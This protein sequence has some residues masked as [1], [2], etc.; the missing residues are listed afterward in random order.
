MKRPDGAPRASAILVLAAIAGVL[1]LVGA[2]LLV[3]PL[4]T[5]AYDGHGLPI[6]T[7]LLASRA[8][9]LDYYLTLWRTLSEATL[10]ALGLHVAIVLTLDRVAAVAS[11]IGR[12]TF[13]GFSLL[14]LTLTAWSRAQHDYHA[15]TLIWQ[16]VRQGGD[17]WWVVDGFLLNSYGPLFNLLAYLVPI[18]PLGPKLLYAA[19]YVGFVGWLAHVSTRPRAA[20]GLPAVVLFG[21]M[22][23]PLAWV[24]IAYFG[25]FDILAGVAGVAALHLQL[26]QRDIAAATWLGLGVLLK[27]MPILLLPFLAIRGRSLHVRVRLIVACTIA[28]GVG[29]TLSTLIWGPGTF[30]PLSSAVGRRAELLSIF[31]FLEGKWSP[32]A[33]VLSPST[34]DRLTTPTLIVAGLAVFTWCWR[35][36]IEPRAAAVAAMLVTL[37]FYK[38]GFVQYQLMLGPL[39]LYWLGTTEQNTRVI[40]AFA[41]YFGWLALFDLFYA[42]IG[43]YLTPDSRWLWI[44]PV[45]GLPTFL[46]GA[47]ALIAL[48]RSPRVRDGAAPA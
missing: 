42:A 26:R 37:L 16:V 25:H 22:L 38:V 34:I 39:V 35:Q 1:W 8:H 28:V 5:A 36:A 13:A 11:P 3:P 29:L 21:A 46:L 9:P 47:W 45:V 43:G 17:P 15:H 27:Y 20:L 4:V 30:R 48:L 32:V 2:R 24:E 33:S 44:G 41:V 40:A 18:N 23:N 7:R 19:A 10:I 12:R 6:L 14:F 31:A